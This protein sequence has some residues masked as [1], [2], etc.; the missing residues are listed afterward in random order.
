[1]RATVRT[2]CD[3]LNISSPPASVHLKQ[4]KSGARVRV[5]AWSRTP[6]DKPFLAWLQE[7]FKATEVDMGTGS[8]N[9][10]ICDLEDPGWMGEA[11]LGEVDVSH[12]VLEP[13]GQVM[14]HILGEKPAIETLLAKLSPGEDDA[15][16]ESLHETSVQEDAPRELLTDRQRSV[17]K[18]A[19]EEGYYDIPRTTKLR[20]LAETLDTSSATL[21]EILRRTERRL[22]EHHLETY[23]DEPE[24]PSA[25]QPEGKRSLNPRD[26]NRTDENETE[27][28]S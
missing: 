27:R 13:E 14:L 19:L 18:V 22:A 7:A 25:P 5:F 28:R 6:I 17:L 15:V 3:A 10:A 16:L 4:L 11:P 8:A 12:V 9:L 20:D 23:R 2:T 21:S 26:P 1:M 24:P